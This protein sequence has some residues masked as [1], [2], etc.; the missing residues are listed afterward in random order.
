MATQKTIEKIGEVTII[1]AGDV[2]STDEQIEEICAKSEELLSKENR[3]ILAAEIESDLHALREKVFV[4]H[5]YSYM[6]LLS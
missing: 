6:A 5:M 1:P 2:F 3:S 4:S